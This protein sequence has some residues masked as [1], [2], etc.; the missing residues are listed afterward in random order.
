MVDDVEKKLLENW[1][2]KENIYLE[3]Y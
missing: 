3:R 2:K 1:I